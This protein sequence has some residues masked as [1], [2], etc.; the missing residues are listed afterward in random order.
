MRSELGLF[1][2]LFLLDAARLENQNWFQVVLNLNKIKLILQIYYA[3]SICC[4]I[5]LQ[6]SNF[7][8]SKRSAS[9]AAKRPKNEVFKGSR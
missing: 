6:S 1:D 9:G 3:R 4:K 2:R 7:R 5:Y 8:F